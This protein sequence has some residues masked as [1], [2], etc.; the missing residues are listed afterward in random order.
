MANAQTFLASL[1]QADIGTLSRNL[2]LLVSHLDTKVGEVPVAEL[3]AS[4][5][6]VLVKADST[7]KRIDSASARLDA[8]LGDPALKQT[9]ENAAV[10]SARL[11]KIADDGDLDRMVNGIDDAAERLDVML[12]DN[13]YDVR[14]IVQD[15]RVTA[16][17]L[18]ALSETLKRDPAGILVGGPPKKIRLP[19]DSQ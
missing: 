18:R 14:T 8:L 16:D 10:I 2:N 4:A 5:H 1:N 6:D 9:V 13:Q 15:L 3:S 11:R 17:N 19:E 12:G 7:L